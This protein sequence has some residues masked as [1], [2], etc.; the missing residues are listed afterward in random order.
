M[1]IYYNTTPHETEVP[2]AQSANLFGGERPGHFCDR[3]ATMSGTLD[4]NAIRDA[5]LVTSVLRPVCK[6]RVSVF[7]MPVLTSTECIL[8]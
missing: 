5:K 7:G 2:F 8:T 6:V 3:E 4:Q 1:L